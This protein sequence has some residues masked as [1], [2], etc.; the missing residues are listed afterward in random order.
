[1]KDDFVCI[2]AFYEAGF[3]GPKHCQPCLGRRKSA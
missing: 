1:M 2:P 3:L